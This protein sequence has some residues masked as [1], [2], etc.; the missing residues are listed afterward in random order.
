MKYEIEREIGGCSLG[1][2]VYQERLDYDNN[3]PYDME[4]VSLDHVE[5]RELRDKLNELLGE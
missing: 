2:L 4:Y 3:D 5:M 1:I